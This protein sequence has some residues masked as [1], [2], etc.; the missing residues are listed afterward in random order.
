MSNLERQREFRKRHPGYDRKRKS[1]LRAAMPT[2]RPGLSFAEPL[3]APEESAL[4]SPALSTS[5]QMLRI[6]GVTAVPT[7]AELQA[8]AEPSAA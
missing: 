2:A 5:A 4:R 7:Q 6:P 3:A 8:M 1:A